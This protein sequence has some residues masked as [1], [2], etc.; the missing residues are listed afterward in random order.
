[1]TTTPT[2]TDVPTAHAGLVSITKDSTELEIRAAMAENHVRV[3]NYL[4]TEFAVFKGL[5]LAELLELGQNE[6]HQK[7][8]INYISIKA[9]FDQYEVPQHWAVLAM[10]MYLPQDLSRWIA[11][12]DPDY[13]VGRV[14][15]NVFL[16]TSVFDNLLFGVFAKMGAKY[17]KRGMEQTTDQCVPNAQAIVT[18]TL[19]DWTQRW[20]NANPEVAAKIVE[21]MERHAP[22]GEK[23]EEEKKGEEEMKVEV[24]PADGVGLPHG[25]DDMTWGERHG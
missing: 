3:Y 19:Q 13:I 20:N 25:D 15:V 17:V 6:V 10:A 4:R 11:R 23:V 1:M 12:T 5:F 9:I 18:R 7:E 22:K 16:I 21:V 2:E 14:L 24:E 8:G